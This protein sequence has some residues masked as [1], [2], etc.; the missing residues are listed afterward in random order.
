VLHHLSVIT[1]DVA[2]STGEHVCCLAKPPLAATIATTTPLLAPSRIAPLIG[3]D[4]RRLL[5]S[6]RNETARI[7]RT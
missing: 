2:R 5:S 4:E 3:A 6:K 7:A 1:A